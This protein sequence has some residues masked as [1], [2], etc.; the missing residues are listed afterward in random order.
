MDVP[1][2]SICEMVQKNVC[3]IVAQAHK[4]YKL[5]CG[6][7]NTCI[8]EALPQNGEQVVYMIGAIYCQ[9]CSE[10]VKSTKLGTN[11]LKT[12]LIIFKGSAK[13]N[14]ALLSNCC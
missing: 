7:N 6:V 13:N 3:K 10:S 14:K 8:C 11:V 4:S 9:N 2:S 1:T 12:M 5:V